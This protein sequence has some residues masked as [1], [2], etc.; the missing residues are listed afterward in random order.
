MIHFMM[1]KIFEALII[2]HQL[3]PLKLVFKTLK[4]S[5]IH[6]NPCSVDPNL[7]V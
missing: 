7:L 6:S 1:F 2:D 5:G 3:K 4:K